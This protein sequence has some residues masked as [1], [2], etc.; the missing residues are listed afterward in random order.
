[1]K[2]ESLLATVGARIRALRER[3]GMSRR[4]LSDSSG[5]SERFLA[6]LESGHGNISL[7]R[8]ADVAGALGT[9][10]ADLLAGAAQGPAPTVALLGVRGAGKSTIGQRLASKRKIPFIEVDQQIEQVAGIALSVIFELHGE[11]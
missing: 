9:S 4:Q 1:M 11:A 5:V 7:A 10:P 6:Q 8:F 2:R 3:R